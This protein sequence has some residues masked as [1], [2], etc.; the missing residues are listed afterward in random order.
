M[1]KYIGAL[2]KTADGYAI[3]GTADL[4]S[5]GKKPFKCHFDAKGRFT[6]FESL[7]DEAKL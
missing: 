3:Q 6:T 4:G 1:V 7:V 2:M 5:Q